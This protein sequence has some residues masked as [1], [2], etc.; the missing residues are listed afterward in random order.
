[1]NLDFV[2]II[3]FHWFNLTNVSYKYFF[4]NQVA[5]KFNS[6]RQLLISHNEVLELTLIHPK[7]ID[8][9]PSEGISWYFVSISYFL[10]QLSQ[11]LVVPP[12]SSNF[13]FSKWDSNN[14]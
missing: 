2:A 9:L 6:F 8:D 12:M 3:W 10:R 14:L 5:I 4:T 13:L 1:M 7:I 11:Q